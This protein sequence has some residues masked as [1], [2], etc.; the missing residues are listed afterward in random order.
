M[1]VR[2][3]CKSWRR[4]WG[5]GLG[6]IEGHCLPVGLTGRR[7]YWACLCPGE[8]VEY[9]KVISSEDGEATTRVGGGPKG[10]T[11]PCAVPARLSSARAAVA[12]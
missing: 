11:L 3:Q 10:V 9:S 4:L 8:R 6:R 2:N 1:W 12:W 5:R 7:M